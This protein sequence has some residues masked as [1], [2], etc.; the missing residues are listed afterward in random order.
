[1][2]TSRRRT[3]SRL[4]AVVAVV[5]LSFF[6][7]VYHSL[8]LCE[9]DR[10]VSSNQTNSRLQQTLP[11]LASARAYDCVVSPDTYIVVVDLNSY[12]MFSLDG[13]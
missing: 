11:T 4:R 2:V 1:M 5:I 7:S 12:V 3:W 6:L 8:A 13:I 9:Y 10:T